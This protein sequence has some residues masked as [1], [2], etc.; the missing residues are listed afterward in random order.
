MLHKDTLFRLDVYPNIKECSIQT[1]NDQ[2]KNER[3]QSRILPL[4][5]ENLEKCV[6]LQELMPYW[7]YFSVNPM[8][9]WKRNAESVKKIQ[10]RIVDIDTGTKQEQQKL[11]ENAP[12]IP[13]FVV[14]SVHWFHIYYLATEKL[15]KEQYE[16]GNLWLMQYYH[17]DIK[18]CKDIARVLRIPGYYHCKGEKQLVIL[19]DDLFC[20]QSYT[21]DQMLLKFPYVEEEKNPEVVTRQIEKK[22]DDNDSFRYKVNNLDNRTVLSDLSGTSFVGWQKITFKPCSTWQQIYCDDKETSCWIDHNW[23]IGSSDDWWPTFIQYLRRYERNRGIPLDMWKLAKWLKETYPRLEDKKPKKF[24]IKE[25]KQKEKEWPPKWFLYADKVFDEFECFLSW[26]LV[27]LV[28]ETNS[29][30][31]TFAM[32]LMARNTTRGRKWIYINLEFPAETVWKNRW[33]WIHGKTKQ[34]LSDLAPLSEQEENEMSAYVTEKMKTFDTYSNPNWMDLQDL[35]KLIYE[36]VEEWYELFIVDSL[37]RIHGNTDGQN[38]RGY[39]NKCMEELQE[40]V[41]KLDIAIVL[42]HHTNKFWKF[43]WSQKIADLSNVFMFI[44]KE[45]DVYWWDC[46]KYTLYKDKFVTTKE[47]KV[48][49]SWWVYEKL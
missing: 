19:R 9:S 33:L 8:E 36:K 44:Q 43:E 23:M 26:E 41:Q 24:E 38:S 47:M 35:E 2:D 10:T 31:T 12:L 45:Q 25:I 14:E 3:S 27:T 40:M 29:W 1:F 15:T 17:W 4:T 49:Y 6:K 37:S 7:I 20:G 22:R 34:N 5:R 18:V 46:R 30:K 42:L 32:D 48:R 13:S 21:Y 11:I 16:K 39:Q 28:A